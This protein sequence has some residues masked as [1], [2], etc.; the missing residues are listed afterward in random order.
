VSH[1]VRLS[2]LAIADLI[3]L[4]GW[5]VEQADRAT[6]D[7]YLARIEARL[8]ALADFPHRG[9][10]RGDL[11]P[12]VRTLAFERRLVIA[13]R[14]EDAVVTVLRVVS[15]ARDLGGGFAAAGGAA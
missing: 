11:G 7:G 12:G 14:A 10:P 13:Y 2:P 6:A 1:A 5:V 3:A 9:T 15:G 4:H 8:A